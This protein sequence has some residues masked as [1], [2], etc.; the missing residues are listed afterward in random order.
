MKK[1]EDYLKRIGFDSRKGFALGMVLLLAVAGVAYAHFARQDGSVG[2]FGYGYGYGYGWDQGGYAGH[3]T[4][5]AE[6]PSVYGYGYL[7]EDSETPGDSSWIAA[8]NLYRIDATDK[9]LEESGK[10]ITVDIS[11]IQP[12]KEF[13]SIKVEGDSGTVTTDTVTA[14]ERYTFTM[15]SEGVTVKVTLKST[16]TTS[17]RTT[18]DTDDED[19][20]VDDEDVE[21][22][23]EEEKEL[24]EMTVKELRGVLADLVKQAIGLLKQRLSFLL[25]GEEYIDDYIKE[26]TEE[27]EIDCE[28]TSFNRN[29]QI[30]MSGSDVKCLQVVLNS[31]FDTQVAVTGVGS[32]GNETEYFGALTQAAAV[33][34]QEKYA[35]EIL[36]PLGLTSGTGYVGSSTRS[37]LNQ[38]LTQQNRKRKPR[39]LGGA[40]V[41][42]R[43]YLLYFL[44]NYFNVSILNSEVNSLLAS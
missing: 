27:K 2:E 34:S 37:K 7:I 24:S 39:L 9:E 25:G 18:I 26:H 11:N 6:D 12:G 14:G 17:S 23:T 15:P 22:K 28:I 1:T 29:L 36:T 40:F 21:E 20:D 32:S 13:S 43:L 10:T 19:E 4:G 44:F 42:F 3:R 5:G 41:I 33:K 30:G 8:E 38:L 16:T 35:S 31:S